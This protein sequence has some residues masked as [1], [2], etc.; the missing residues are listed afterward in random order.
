MNIEEELKTNN[1]KNE[2]HKAVLNILFTASSLRAN[3]N[4]RLKVHKLSQEQ[5]NVLRIL[6][7]QYPKALCLKEITNRMIE[8]NSNTTR[9]IEKL[10]A[11]NFVVRT[12]SQ[13]DKRELE[14]SINQLG[15]DT[16]AAID[17][18]METENLDYINL[19]V[20]EAKMLNLLLDKT[21]S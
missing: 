10:D 8:R 18:L 20:Q 9:I 5:Y 16:L 1:F 14:I 2:H 13:I 15:L 4:Q 17:V 6:R 3:I 12:V 21:R 7:G 11:K 19:S